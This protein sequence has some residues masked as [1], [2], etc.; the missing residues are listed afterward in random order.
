M[1]YMDFA[2]ERQCVF[3]GF[4]TDD[5]YE[6]ARPTLPLYASSDDD[7]QHRAHVGFEQEAAMHGCRRVYSDGTEDEPQNRRIFAKS[8]WTLMQSHNLTA[9][10]H[11]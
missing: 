7:L 10:A 1:G 9:N 4:E 11:T 6:S 3:W 2:D 5:P 8:D